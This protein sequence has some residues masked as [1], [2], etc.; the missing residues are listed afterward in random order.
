MAHT[1]KNAIRSFLYSSCESI[2]ALWATSFLLSTPPLSPLSPLCG[3]LALHSSRVQ[4][5][6]DAP[7][8]NRKGAHMACMAL[9]GGALSPN[10][11]H[12]HRHKGRKEEMLLAMH[13]RRYECTCAACASVITN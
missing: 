4:E 9:R 11:P 1:L 8:R 12:L 13:L 5:S 2:P 6:G 3:A 10:R 7:A